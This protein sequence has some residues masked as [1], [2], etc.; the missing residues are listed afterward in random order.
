MKF[1]GVLTVI[2]NLNE[3][4]EKL[5]EITS[6]KKMKVKRVKWA[7]RVLW[8]EYLPEVNRSVTSECEQRLD[9]AVLFGQNDV[10]SPGEQRESARVALHRALVM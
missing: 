5:I 1:D 4:R 10:E 2:N 9:G 7:R 8:M 6:G 3:E